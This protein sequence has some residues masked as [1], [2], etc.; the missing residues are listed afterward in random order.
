M[1]FKGKTVYQ[2]YPKSF[3]DTNGDGWGDFQV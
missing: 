3:C 2:I 1:D